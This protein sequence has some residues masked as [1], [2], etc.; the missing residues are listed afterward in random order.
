MKTLITTPDGYMVQLSNGE[1]MED[2]N[3]N[4]LFDNIAD[5]LMLMHTEG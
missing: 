3:G 4:N 1:Y 2:K 5:A